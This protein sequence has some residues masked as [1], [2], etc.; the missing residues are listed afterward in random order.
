M[1]QNMV[2]ST[3]DGLVCRTRLAKYLYKSS[4]TVIIAEQTK[5]TVLRHSCAKAVHRD[6]DEFC[7]AVVDVE[8]RVYLGELDDARV[9]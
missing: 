4:N 3:T 1:S 9:C 2:Q 5:R 8:T 7:G 6:G